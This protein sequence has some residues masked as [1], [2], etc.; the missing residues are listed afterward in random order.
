MDGCH[1]Y[2]RMRYGFVAC[3]FAAFCA[4]LWPQIALAENEYA[5]INTNSFLSAICGYT[6]HTAY[7]EVASN[8]YCDIRTS[9]SSLLIN[10]K[11][12][13]FVI[14][15]TNADVQN[16]EIEIP[17][18]DRAVYLGLKTTQSIQNNS[19]VTTYTQSFYCPS[20]SCSLRSSIFIYVTPNA[21]IGNTKTRMSAYTYHSTEKENAANEEAQKNMQKTSELES[22]DNTGAEQ[23]DG[24]SDAVASQ[25]EKA[26]DSIAIV[27]AAGDNAREGTCVFPTDG[28][29]HGIYIGDFFHELDPCADA[30]LPS[31]VKTIGDM[32][33]IALGITTTIFSVR[34]F[35]KYYTAAMRGSLDPESNNLWDGMGSWF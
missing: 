12:V 33:A 1:D 24:S 14:Q 35:N 6:R 7:I 4:L 9:Y 25:T 11:Y 15:T 32:V 26:E 34:L 28:I 30:D 16:T 20:S 22:Q 19:E 10:D 5:Q 2:S 29:G 31:Y 17:D 23:Q 8:N 18:I 3:V 13:D 27:K 21:D